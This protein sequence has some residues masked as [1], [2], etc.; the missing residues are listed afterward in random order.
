MVDELLAQNQASVDGLLLKAR[1][2]LEGGDAAAARE[3]VH[4]AAEVAPDAPAVR[5]MLAHVN[6]QP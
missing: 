4:R 6:A 3:F 5:E 1:I 2:S